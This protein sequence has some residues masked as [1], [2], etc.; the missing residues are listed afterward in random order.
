MKH[1]DSSEW[2]KLMWMKKSIESVHNSKGAKKNFEKACKE[3]MAPWEMLRWYFILL[4]N[5][6]AHQEIDQLTTTSASAYSTTGNA[7]DLEP[8]DL[9]LIDLFPLSTHPG[10]IPNLIVTA[11]S[12]GSLSKPIEGGGGMEDQLGTSY[13][14]IGRDGWEMGQGGIGLERQTSIVP[15]GSRGGPIL[16]VMSR[17]LACGGVRTMAGYHGSKVKSDVGRM[18]R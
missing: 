11:R 2:P 10:D 1:P 3:P 17:G 6:L 16:A 13:K 7:T 15:P 14:Q 5:P 4:R 18:F 12:G 8:E 9:E